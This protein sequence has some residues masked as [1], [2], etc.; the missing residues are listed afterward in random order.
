MKKSLIAFCA[1]A[2]VALMAPSMAHASV[3]FSADFEGSEVGFTDTSTINGAQFLVTSENPFLPSGF[4]S[5]ADQGQGEFLFVNVDESP[6]D[7]PIFTQELEFIA[8]ETYRFSGV[9]A[10]LTF[11]APTISL[12]VGG[13]EVGSFT[14]LEQVGVFQDF[15]FEFVAS[16]TGSL[17]VTLNDSSAA[18]FGPGFTGGGFDFGLDDLILEL[19]DSNALVT[20]IPAAAPLLLSGLALFGAMRRRQAKVETI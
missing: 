12:D 5:V 4:A 20:P 2:S 9:A 18:A 7:F 10:L 14:L 16:V 8:G 1:A 19:V 11:N 3:L 17:V 6:G 13:T 15:A